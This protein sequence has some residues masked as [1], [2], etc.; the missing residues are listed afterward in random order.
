M[1]ATRN[2]CQL[3]SC[4]SLH[5]FGF[6]R[7]FASSRTTHHRMALLCPESSARCSSRCSAAW[8]CAPRSDADDESPSTTRHKLALLLPAVIRRGTHEE[9]VFR[10]G[11]YLVPRQCPLAHRLE[12]KSCDHNS[13]DGAQNQLLGMGGVQ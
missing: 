1:G 12:S 6:G 7:C 13:R 9:G 11:W 10:E 5:A 4:R 8:P 2:T 3:P